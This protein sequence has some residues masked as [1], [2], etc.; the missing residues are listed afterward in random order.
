MAGAADLNTMIGNPPAAVE[1]CQAFFR[2]CPALGPLRQ[3]ASG[4]AFSGALLQQGGNDVVSGNA[5]QPSRGGI[6]PVHR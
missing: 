3:A 4:R 6:D 1:F 2:H 5:A